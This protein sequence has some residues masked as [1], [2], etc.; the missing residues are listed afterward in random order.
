MT[1]TKTMSK[2]KVVL[3]ILLSIAVVLLAVYF[4]IGVYFKS[5]FLFRTQINGVDCAKKT[6]AEV[7]QLIMDEIDDYQLTL[8]GRGEEE[9]IKGQKIQLKPVFDGSLNQVLEACNHFAWPLF[10]FQ[11]TVVELETM[12]E[13]DEAKLS[14]AIEDLNGTNPKVMEAPKDAYISDYIAGKGYEIVAEEEGT[15]VDKKALQEALHQALIN[16]QEEMS[17][18]E[19]GCYRQPKVRAD[20]QKLTETLKELNQ[21]ASTEITYEF[22]EK[23]EVLN[24]EIIHN[25]LTL[26][27]DG[28]IAISQEK[29]AEYVDELAG[30]YNTAKKMRSFAT[31]YG[32][33]VSLPWNEYGWKIDEEQEEAS[34]LEEVKAGTQVSREP[35]YSQRAKSHGENDHGGTYVEINITAQHLFFYKDGALIVESDFVSGNL[36][37]GD[38]T[39]SGAFGLAYKQRD[40]V[41]RGEDYRTPVDFWMPFNGGIGLHDATWRRD[42]GGNYYKSN[43]SHGCINLP[44]NVAEKIF[45][46]IEAA[47][48]VFVY[49]LPGTESAKAQAQEAA[50]SVVGMIGAIGEVTADSGGA[51]Q[52]ARAA[53]NALGDQARAYVN[54]YNTLVGAEAAFADIQAW[55]Q[56][57]AQAQA[58]AQPVVD[59]IAGIGEVTLEKEG[60]IADARNR[61]NALSEDAKQYVANGDVLVAA[62]QRLNELKQEQAQKKEEE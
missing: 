14:Q 60:A 21:Y 19:E 25:W 20:D 56:A 30:K 33:T 40:A 1:K 51:I 43:G 13:Y 35:A 55:Q 17:L 42:F 9:V 15:T 26:E 47:D 32:S 31:S 49:E 8:T 59:A 18:E 46:H 37:R 23:R 27:A 57:Q 48:A 4:G 50:S 61:Y 38:G 11:P 53:Y 44:Y 34:I 12:V 24:G 10:L 5:H 41:L 36:A 58:D 16:L 7:E 3:L 22:G 45:N 52:N 54:N 2:K 62:E 28:T 39:P 29:I 6:V